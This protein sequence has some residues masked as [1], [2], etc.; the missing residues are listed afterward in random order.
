MNNKY[1]LRDLG[2]AQVS[3]L[4]GREKAR[5]WFIQNWRG[6]INQYWRAWASKEGQQKDRQ[7]WTIDLTLQFWCSTSGLSQNHCLSTSVLFSGQKVAPTF[8]LR[9]ISW[10]CE[11][12]VFC[13][14]QSIWTYQGQSGTLAWWYHKLQL[15]RKSPKFL[16][17]R[18]RALHN[19]CTSQVITTMTTYRCYLIM[20]KKW[21]WWL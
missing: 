6:W 21:W 13:I 14:N 1:L 20:T 18:C 10:T 2:R 11:S 9:K 19:L 15:W 16:N 5:I 7:T 17:V 12:P 3:Q 4:G 8:Q